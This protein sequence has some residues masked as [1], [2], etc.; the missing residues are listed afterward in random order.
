MDVDYPLSANEL[1]L[2]RD[3]DLGSE[4]CIVGVLKIV[5]FC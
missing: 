1:E 5:V 4:L 2:I 3:S